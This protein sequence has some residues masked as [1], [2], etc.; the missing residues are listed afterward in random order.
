[1][2]KGY[3]LTAPDVNQLISCYSHEI[4]NPEQPS[5]T[6]VE[7][8]D[9]LFKAMENLAPSRENDEAKGIWVTVP[10]GEITDWST[11][12]E[13]KG[14]DGVKS[15]KEYA[16]LWQDYYPFEMEWYYVCIIENKPDSNWKFRALCRRLLPTLGISH[17]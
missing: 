9:P 1:M 8:M 14:Y 5:A 13:A 11:Y 16:E 15:K 12:K 3:K 7:A 6:L 2:R 4:Q 10:R 17:K